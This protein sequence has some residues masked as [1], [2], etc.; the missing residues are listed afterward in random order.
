M[1]RV[2]DQRESQFIQLFVQMT[3]AQVT[4]ITRA[5]RNRSFQVERCLYR[6][7]T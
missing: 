4:F 6:S 7:A 5:K 3:R 1:D 2:A